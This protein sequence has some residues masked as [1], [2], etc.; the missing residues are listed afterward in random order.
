M[1]IGLRI[2]PGA[3]L[4]LGAVR[5]VLNLEVQ[6]GRPEAVEHELT[7]GDLE[8]GCPG[9][10]A[11]DGDGVG[12]CRGRIAGRSGSKAWRRRGSST[13]RI[14]GVVGVETGK[15]PVGLVVMVAKVVLGVTAVL[16]VEDGV[17]V[18]VGVAVA[19]V[20]VEATPGTHWE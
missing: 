18:G 11:E 14:L 5:G 9:V 13:S 4:A 20:V 10:P 1:R 6:R 3:Q 16:R 17:G 12:G 2:K 15:P 8:L 19:V 7:R